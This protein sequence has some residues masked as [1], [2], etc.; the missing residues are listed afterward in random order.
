VRASSKKTNSSNHKTDPGAEKISNSRRRTTSPRERTSSKSP[1][2]QRRANLLRR[3][4]TRKNK[5]ISSK[6]VSAANRPL[7]P[8]Q[9]Q[10]PRVQSR[11]KATTNSHRRPRERAKTVSHP[12]LQRN[13]RRKNLPVKRK[14]L[15]K[16]N[17]KNPRTKVPNWPRPK[18]QK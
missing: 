7:P 11:N 3:H 13:R 18:G 4:R 10:H 16:I 5:E 12:L 15:A 17:H 14:A 9:G 2:N 1:S 6:K 8:V